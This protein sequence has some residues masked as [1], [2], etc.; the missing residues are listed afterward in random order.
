MIY[1]ADHNGDPI[2]QR[3]SDRIVAELQETYYDERWAALREASA[4]AVLIDLHTYPVQ[5]WAIEPDHSSERLEI[6]IGFITGLSPENWVRV[7]TV[8]FEVCGYSVGHNTPYVGVID[9]GA[10][11]AVMIE[12]RRDIVGTPDGCPQWE[13]LVNAMSDMPLLD[14]G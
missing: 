1:S 13:R 12:I 14:L 2:R 6:D 5:P 8:H 10:T 11:A 9:A 4:G 7:L 3:P